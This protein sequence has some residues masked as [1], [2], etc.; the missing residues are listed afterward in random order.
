MADPA[1]VALARRLALKFRCAP[2]HAPDCEEAK[3]EY[4]VYWTRWLRVAAFVLAREKKR[5]KRRKPRG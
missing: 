2:G 4:E 3:Q 5:K 1:V